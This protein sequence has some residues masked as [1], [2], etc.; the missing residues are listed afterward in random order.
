[1][2]SP[3]SLSNVKSIQSYAITHVGIVR[4]VLH[5][6]QNA[7]WS[8][9]RDRYASCC[10]TALPYP[11]E[12]TI[13]TRPAEV[14]PFYFSNSLQC[15]E[16]WWAEYYS[17][18]RHTK[19]PSLLARTVIPSKY[20]FVWATHSLSSIHDYYGIIRIEIFQRHFLNNKFLVKS[21]LVLLLLRKS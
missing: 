20:S 12:R 2:S 13:S 10:P 17:K 6:L 14:S 8:I 1:M 18:R 9:W 3:T 16:D 7:R 15:L 19:V 4:I 5:S 21:C 11:L